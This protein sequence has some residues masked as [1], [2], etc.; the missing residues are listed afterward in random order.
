MSC[1]VHSVVLNLS[2]KQ[3]RLY[4]SRTHLSIIAKIN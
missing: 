2:L 1:V 3:N 4:F